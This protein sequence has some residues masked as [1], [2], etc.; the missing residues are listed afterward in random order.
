MIRRIVGFVMDDEG[1]FVARIDCGHGQHMRHKPPMT[2]RPWVLT[3]EGRAERVGMDI[4]CP[5]CDRAEMPAG[6]AEYKRTAVFDES[7]VRRGLLGEHRTKVG[8]WGMLHVIEGEI[9]FILLEPERSVTTLAAGSTHVIVSGVA[10]QVAL[11]TA[12]PRARF[13]VAFYGPPPK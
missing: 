7:T 1:H 13:Y 10:H 2:F 4:E 11:R 12:H 5:L 3:E 9:D 8:V 6:Y